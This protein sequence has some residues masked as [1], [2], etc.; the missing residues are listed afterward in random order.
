MLRF[1]AYF[2]EDV[3]YS[4]EEHYRVRPV[5]IYYY[6]EDDT[7]CIIEPTVENSGIPQG[8]RIKRQHLPKNEFGAHY[9][10]TDLN[11]AMDLEVYGVRYHI[12][13]CDTFTKVQTIYLTIFI[14]AFI[15]S[16]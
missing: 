15:Q 1:Y 3:I 5:V 4:Q 13:H 14:A 12:T 8:K 2:T 9:Q 10:W 16:A 6:L 7:M 11:V